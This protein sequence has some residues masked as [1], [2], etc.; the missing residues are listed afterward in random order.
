MTKLTPDAALERARAELDLKP[1]VEGKAWPVHPAS[2]E[3]VSYFL[4]LLGDPGAPIAA[5]AVDSTSGDVIS[6]AR[7]SGSL[8]HLSIA[9][10]EAVR[11]TGMPEGSATRLVWEP[12]RQTRSPLYPVWEVRNGSERAY[13]DQRGLTWRRLGPSR[14]GGGQ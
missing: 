1:P 11:R 10:D 14:P 7:L 13:V 8:P 3:G 5:V 2:G 6:S 12:S 4:V 9:A